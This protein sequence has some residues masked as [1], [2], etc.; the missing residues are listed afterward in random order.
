MSASRIPTSC[1]SAASAAARLTVSDD[2][3]TPPLPE[4]TA[5][6]R[7]FGDELDALAL[8]AAA[9]LRRQRGALVGRHHVEGSVTDATPGSA[10][11]CS[12][13]WSS[14]LERSGQP[15]TVSA[16]V[17]RDVAA[18]DRE[19]ADHVELGDGAP[20][21][22]IDHA[23]ERREDLFVGGHSSEGSRLSRAGRPPAAGRARRFAAAATR[24]RPTRSSGASPNGGAS[25]S[26]M[27]APAR[28]RAAARRRC[29]PSARALS[30]TTPSTRP[31]ARWQSEIASEPMIAQ[32]VRD[33]VEARRALGDVRGRGR[34]EREDLELRPSAAPSA[35]RRSGTRRRRA[36]PSTPRRCRSRRR[37]RRRRR[38]SC[39]RPRP[40]SRSRRTGCRASRSASRRSGRRRP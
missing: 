8:D 35:A 22:R 15:A 28:A 38:P 36:S 14:K 25:G 39:R 11:T 16:I 24:E 30:E 7:V 40:R 6:T 13:T 9:Q 31:A 29:R 27:R 32:P 3:P 34:L 23:A 26:S 17:T 21:L 1:P 18:V 5:S 20:E 19:V 2:L 12:A 4:A 33:P 37:S 10:P